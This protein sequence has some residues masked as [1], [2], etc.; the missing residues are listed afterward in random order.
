MGLLDQ[1]LGGVTGSQGST[2]STSPLVK[3][4]LVLLAAKAYTTYTHRSQQPEAARPQGTP[5]PSSDTIQSGMLKGMPSL[6][7]LGHLVER[8][9]KGGLGGP[10]Q[11]WVGPGQNQ[12]VTPDQLHDALGPDVV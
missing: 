11:S 7:G 8:L 12:P 2:S 3:A 10:V 1:V 6:S 9:T 4:L 5:A